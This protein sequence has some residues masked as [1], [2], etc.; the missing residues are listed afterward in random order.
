VGGDQPEID[1]LVPENSFVQMDCDVDKLT[2]TRLTWTRNSSPLNIVA[3]GR[4][5][6]DGGPPT[7]RQMRVSRGGRVLQFESTSL[8]QSGVYVCTVQNVAG[9]VRKTYNLQVTGAFFCLFELGRHIL[10]ALH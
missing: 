6:V 7:P 5:E 2:D 8:N 10:N 9:L 4:G 1:I 3:S